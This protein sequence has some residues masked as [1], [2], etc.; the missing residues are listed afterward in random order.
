MI[1]LRTAFNVTFDGVVITGTMAL[2]SVKD[3]DRLVKVLNAQKAAL[4]AMQDDDG[5][6]IDITDLIEAR[7]LADD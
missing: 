7:Q 3:I 5:L 6:E 4:E 2:R 1:D